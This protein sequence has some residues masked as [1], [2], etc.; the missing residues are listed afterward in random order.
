MGDELRQRVTMKKLEM[1]KM[2]S[3]E[4]VEGEQFFDLMEET[5]DE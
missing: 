4:T 5:V 2:K 1:Q 3:E